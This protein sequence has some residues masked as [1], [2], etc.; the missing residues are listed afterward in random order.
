MLRGVVPGK[1]YV[2]INERNGNGDSFRNLF[3]TQGNEALYHLRYILENASDYKSA[4]DMAR[5]HSLLARAYYSIMGTTGNEGC[6]I[7]RTE[8]GIH[9]EY[10]L[11]DDV[12]FLVQTNTDRDL[13]DPDND[14]RRTPAENYLS[15]TVG[16][17]NMTRDNLKFL[18]THAPNH[19]G[20]DDPF[21]PYGTITTILG[22]H[23]QGD[24]KLF[25]V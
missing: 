6:V 13:P 23:N 10:C 2:S 5:N 16:R 25:D 14:C 8:S 19:V 17:Q 1:F 9:N 4:L 24:D 11:S 15:A 18:L 12:W 21:D 7:E 20:A 3:F 22:Q